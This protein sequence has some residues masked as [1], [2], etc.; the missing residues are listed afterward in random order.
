MSSTHIST[1]NFHLPDELI[2]KLRAH[3]GK[4][5]KKIEKFVTDAVSSKIEEIDSNPPYYTK[6]FC[7]MILE[8]TKKFDTDPSERGVTLTGKKEIYDYFSAVI[9]EFEDEEKKK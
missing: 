5:L 7:D 8:R 4:S 6:E 1:P 3:F 9:K 2:E